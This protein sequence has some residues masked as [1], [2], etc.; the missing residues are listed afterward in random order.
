VKVSVS[1]DWRPLGEVRLK[2]NALV[3]PQLTDGPGVYRFRF[4][5]QGTD[6]SYVGEA[7]QLRRRAYHYA[8]P[9]PSQATN[10]RM[11]AEMREHLV[12]G[13]RIEMS[14]ITEAQIEIEGRT[15]GLN[16]AEASSRRLVENAVLRGLRE[17]G[18]ERILNRP[19]VGESW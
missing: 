7:S 15:A 11:N 4:S 14:V 8:R 16:L 3:F 1:F 9:G 18:L 10:I 2:G 5:G 12:A 19:G 6:G 13:G 17:T